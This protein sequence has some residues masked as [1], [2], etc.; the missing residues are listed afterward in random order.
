VS[1]SNGIAGRR[2]L[3][4]GSVTGIGRAIAEALAEAGAGVVAHG[5]DSKETRDVAGQ[6]RARGF[7]VCES[8]ADLAA[9]N[10]VARLKDQV[11]GWGA[12]DILVINASIEI[13][14]TWESASLE[15]MQRQ[16]M[17]NIWSS[18]LL[19]QAFLPSMLA[20]DWGRVVAIGSIQESRPNAHH[21]T[22]AATKAAQT[23][24]ILNLARNVRAP[25]VTFNVLK[26]GVIATHRNAEALANV[27]RQREILRGTPL[28]RIGMPADC[29]GAA[30]LLCSEG[31]R[32]MN[33][34]ELHVDGGYRL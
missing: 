27:D 20:R 3:V 33:G 25:N 12:P 34:A 9:A 10:G 14:E 1:D 13:A 22:Y 4:T 15:A 11:A 21:I 26:P 19:I 24:M 5:L 17:V 31:G 7:D 28:G 2:A 8:D 32:Y 23:S 29:V 30:L 16:G 6:W 18:V